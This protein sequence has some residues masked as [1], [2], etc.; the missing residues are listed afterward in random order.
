MEA[1]RQSHLV[2]RYHFVTEEKAGGITYTPK[3]LADFVA[4]K[5]LQAA[6]K[7]P[8]NRRIRV[9]DP[10]IGDGELLVSL[11]DDLTSQTDLTIEVNGFETNRKALDTATARIKEQF[12]NVLQHFE[13][14]NFLEHVFEHF[15]CND[16]TS[17]FG[18][19]A[20]KTYDLI[21]ANPP[22]VRTQILG[23][24]RAQLL[25]KQFNLTG[26]VD[27][28][29]A[30]V[31]GI[32]RVLSPNGIAGII[33]SN[34]FMTTRSGSSVRQALLERLHV[35]HVWDLGDT[36]LFNAAVLPAVLLAENK[37][38]RNK[39][40]P[41]FTSIYQ[42]SSSAKEIT[43]DPLNALGGEG[44]IEINDGRRFNVRHGKL[45]TSGTFGG[46]W[47]IT[48]K[49]VDAW[50]ATVNVHSWGTFRDIG[51]IRVGVKTC[52]DK[53]FIRS[54]W[55]NIPKN[56]LP[57]L[58]KPITTH[59]IARRF[60]PLNEQQLTRILYPH[61]AVQGRRHAVDLAEYPCSKAYLETHR[62][63][64]ENRKYLTKSGRKW[65][66][67]WVPQD[68]DAWR[69]PKLVFRDIASEPTFWIDLDG[70]IVNGDCYWLA[71]KNPA[72]VDLLWLAAAVG[73]STFAEQ[74]YDYRFNNKLYAG[75]RRYITQYVEKFPL[76]D[77]QTS[78]SKTII[79]KAKQ[80]Y[81][82]T[83]SDKVSQLQQE[84]NNLIWK[85]FGLTAEEGGRE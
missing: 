36:K 71:C 17:M 83:P 3:I 43:T 69:C 11:L 34:R 44:V 33:V 27:L 51:K 15:S 63:I 74:F 25:A 76:P 84:L 28:Y 14:G 50:L 81:D 77:P 67:I 12:P 58:L 60:K 16:Q 19:V 82:C 7:L 32:S 24:D 26:R 9:F 85:S 78:L 49:A 57:E 40:T 65:F 21:I 18:S 37:N 1:L 4:G 38:G 2:K 13:S 62:A 29:H 6:S 47:R 46:V 56:D 54:D 45:D 75:R 73:N 79:A 64:L 53:V 30:F 61:K 35:R 23:A 42:T 41:G 80:I 59:R 68:P 20:P 22:Y 48:T 72:Q 70:S 31:L 55:Q 52:A 10:A 5:I 66:E 8:T 39:K